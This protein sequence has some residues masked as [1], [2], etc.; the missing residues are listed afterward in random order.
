[1]MTQTKL[2]LR[3]GV[4]FAS[5]LAGL[6]VLVALT[7]LRM[8]VGS[9]LGIQ[10]VIALDKNNTFI[11]GSERTCFSPEGCLGRECSLY[12][13]HQ[14]A[15]YVCFSPNRKVEDGS[16]CPHFFSDALR[17]AFGGKLWLIPLIF[18]V[19]AVLL[20]LLLVRLTLCLGTRTL[21]VL[22]FVSRALFLISSL[23]LLVGISWSPNGSLNYWTDDP[24]HFGFLSREILT[25]LSLILLLGESWVVIH[26][27][28]SSYHAAH[29]THHSILSE[30]A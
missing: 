5:A 18:P 29:H 30:D 10:D 13:L 21:L 26:H 3:Y 14:E 24:L 23:A 17:I 12:A 2:W 11:P 1:M 20:N 7:H 25:A 15:R 27:R 22:F 9:N 16:V 6:H 19:M 8:V 28:V 4:L